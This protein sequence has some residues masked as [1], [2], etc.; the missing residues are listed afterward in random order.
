MHD[1]ALG[2]KVLGTAEA[3]VARSREAER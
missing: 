3:L 1:A 2:R